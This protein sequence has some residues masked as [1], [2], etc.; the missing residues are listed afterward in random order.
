[1]SLEILRAMAERRC[2]MAM[3]DGYVRFFSP[4]ALG[5][6]EMACRDL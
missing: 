1:M 4:H 2:V 5:V 6:R 3:Y